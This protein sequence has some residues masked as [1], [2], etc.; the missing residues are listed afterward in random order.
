M[1]NSYTATLL[2]YYE[3]SS[4]FWILSGAMKPSPNMGFRFRV[5]G[6]LSRFHS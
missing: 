5:S 1:K 3:N 4:F 6:Q 2:I